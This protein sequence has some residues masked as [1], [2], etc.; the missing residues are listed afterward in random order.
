MADARPLYVAPPVPVLQYASGPGGTTDTGMWMDGDTLVVRNGY[1][2]PARCV[3]CN[4]PVGTMVTRKYYWHHPGY[5]FL[6]LAHIL[7][8]AVVAMVVRKSGTVR[9]GLCDDHRVRRRNGLLIAWLCGLG[10]IM[11]LIGG[12]VACASTNGKP[13]AIIPIVVG[14]ISMVAGLV[15]GSIQ[16]RILKAKKI[17]DQFL[18][19]SGACLDFLQADGVQAMPTVGMVSPA[20]PP[21]LR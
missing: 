8:Y 19:L 7:I 11:V 16:A 5:Y 4:A 2:L 1:T 14:F 13:W 3:K 15:I 18:W 12:I 6:I 20:I 21:P 9:I 10:G 17:D